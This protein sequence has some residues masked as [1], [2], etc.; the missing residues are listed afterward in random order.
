[1]SRGAL[2]ERWRQMLQRRLRHARF[3]EQTSQI[4]LRLKI[5]LIGE[6]VL[7]GTSAATL[8]LWVRLRRRL[9]R[10]I[11]L[12]GQA[13]GFVSPGDR[14]LQRLLRLLC[15]AVLAQLVVMAGLA[16]AAVPGQ[17]PLAITVLMQ[18]LAILFK[19]ALLGLLAAALRWLARF[20]LRQWVSYL[21]VPLEERA[22]RQQRYLNLR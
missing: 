12:E 6:L 8:A 22:R 15:I 7:A 2:A 4:S 11:D 5:T 18:P 3:T 14:W 21:A 19:V 10:R 9:Q 17:I 20:V 1:M 16:V 13:S